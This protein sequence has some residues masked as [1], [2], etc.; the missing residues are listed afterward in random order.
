[1]VFLRL[2]PQPAKLCVDGVFA[3][4]HIK[5]LRG[6]QH[7]KASKSLLV[8]SASTIGVR[9]GLYKA[10]WKVWQTITYL[11]LQNGV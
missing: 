9:Q 5:Q 2:L 6:G 10:F 4:R 3:H 11:D 7:L 1:M 8:R